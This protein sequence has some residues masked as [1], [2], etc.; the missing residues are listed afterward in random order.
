MTLEEL[1]KLIK[2]LVWEELNGDETLWA[3]N[4][5]DPSTFIFQNEDGTWY[6]YA[7]DQDH[8]TK[9]EAMESVEELHVR[10][11]ARRLYLDDED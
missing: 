5:I 6:S 9:E 11:L 4:C 7:D 10:E 8:N 2:P 1:K 3:P